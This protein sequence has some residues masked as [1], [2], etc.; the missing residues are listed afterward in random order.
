LLSAAAAAAPHAPPAAAAPHAP[1][2]EV[3]STEV[4]SASDGAGDGASGTNS[5]KSQL[6]NGFL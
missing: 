5:Q 2:T 3:S 1:P 4:T 6:D